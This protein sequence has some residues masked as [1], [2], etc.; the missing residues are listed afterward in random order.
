[1]HTNKQ[2]D[3][4]REGYTRKYA[5][6]YLGILQEETNNPNYNQEFV[7][8]AHSRGFRAEVASIYHVTDDSCEDYLTDYDYY[9]LWPLNSWERIWINDKLTLKYMLVGTEYGGLMPEYY[10]YTAEDGLKALLDNPYRSKKQNLEVFAAVLREKGVFACKPC[11]GS[12]SVGFFKLA[13][14]DGDYYYN[15]KRITID[16][17]ETILM[18]SRN[19]VFTEYIRPNGLFRKMS[20]QIHTLR[21]VT[22]NEEGHEPKIIGGYLRVPHESSSEA[23]YL[24]FQN[25][26]EYN[27]VMDFDPE[28]GAFCDARKI[29]FNREERVDTH[30]DTGAALSGVIPDYAKLKEMVLGVA[31]H[32]NT[33]EYMGFDIGVTDK[34]FKCMEIN[35]H[36]GIGHMQLYHP[37]FKDPRTSSYFRKKLDVLAALTEEEKKTRIG[38]PR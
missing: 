1:M 30:P 37:F 22:V 15:D 19:C 26:D 38:I 13:Y 32:F 14:Q 11:N 12:T 9:K 2:E 24:H 8:W 16:E 23:N 27:L 7:A 18:K 21:L 25:I 35:S 6:F 28:S 33:I 36:P 20:E 3:M 17:L 29:F 5:K 10:Y 31:E 34:G 4:L